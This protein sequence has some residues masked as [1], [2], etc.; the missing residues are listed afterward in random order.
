MRIG[1]YIFPTRDNEYT[2]YSLKNSNRTKSHYYYYTKKVTK[3][4]SNRDNPHPDVSQ[5]LRLLI[6]S[7]PCDPISSLRVHHLLVAIAIA[8][9]CIY[10]YIAARDFET[11]TA[12]AGSRGRFPGP[13]SC[14]ARH[15]YHDNGPYCRE[16][17][18][19]N[20]LAAAIL[21]GARASAA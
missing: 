11:T 3:H 12:A 5:L 15:E 10:I 16:R 9:R 19:V 6:S 4:T 20:S 13:E 7:H 14:A 18:T 2:Y 1:R 17:E 21:S 8:T